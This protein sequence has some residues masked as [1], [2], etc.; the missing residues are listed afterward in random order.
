M[1]DANKK[2]TLD[3]AK[4]YAQWLLSKG[5]ITNFPNTEQLRSAI[6]V[7]MSLGFSTYG[8]V[9]SALQEMYSYQGKIQIFGSLPL[10]L[11][12]KT[13]QLQDIQEFFV[14][15]DG[16]E[17][18]YKNGNLNEKPVVAVCR[19]KRKGMEDFCEYSVTSDDL[20]LSG[21][22]ELKEGG[23][24]FKKGNKTWRTH[25]KQMW[26]K[27]AR[28]IGLRSL[29][30]DCLR[31]V[32]VPTNVSEYS[33]EIENV[34]KNSIL[35]GF[36]PKNEKVVKKNPLQENEVEVNLDSQQLDTQIKEVIKDIKDK[37]DWPKTQE[38]N[39]W[40]EDRKKGDKDEKNS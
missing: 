2:M 8:E 33:Q 30:A 26:R 11:I 24:E 40:P 28:N 9:L 7:A 36:K 21:G 17:I 19:L 34:T 29:F 35:E 1:E 10:A 27:T 32:Y 16:K 25:P 14:D 37:E 4:A 38:V 15:K 18:C 39:F 31:N 22:K 6:Q 23:W 20:K 12:Q 13:G 5:I 3:D